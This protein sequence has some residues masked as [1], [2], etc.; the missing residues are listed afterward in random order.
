MIENNQFALHHWGPCLMETSIT[1][2]QIESVKKLCIKDKK[3]DY[4]HELA[5]HLDE[6]FKIDFV[7]FGEIVKESI[8]GYKKA[9]EIWYGDKQFHKTLKVVNA[10]VNYMKPGDFNPP[11]IHLR[12]DLS[13]VVF[14]DVPE[15]L[16]LES[17]KSLSNG[18]SPGELEFFINSHTE[19][20]INQKKFFVSPISPGPGGLKMAA[21][22]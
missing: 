19:G 20:F 12:C 13:G 11:H 6:E 3:K 4:R 7:K 2:D 15:E 22:L 9:S 14:L 10:W 16:M 21:A 8:N 17:K 1:Q 5:G 18:T